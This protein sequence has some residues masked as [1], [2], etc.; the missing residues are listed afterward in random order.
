MVGLQSLPD[1]PHL[2]DLLAKTGWLKDAN[3][4][5]VDNEALVGQLTTFA[6]KQINRNFA[7]LYAQTLIS[8]WSNL[9]N[10]LLTF[11]LSWILNEPTSKEQEQVKNIKVSLAKFGAMS[12][13]ERAEFIFDEIK[14]KRPAPGITQF[15]DLFK[16]FGLPGNVDEVTTRTMFEMF[17]IRNVFAHRGGIADKKFTTDCPWLGYEK[18]D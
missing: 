2:F 16:L 1:A 14:K 15:E 5:D 17:K 7:T 11:L 6:Q 3:R 13:E 10:T 4:N 8:L 9:E 12:E 18:G